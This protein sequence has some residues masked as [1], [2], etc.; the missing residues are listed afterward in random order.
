MIKFSQRMGITPAVKEIQ[1]N[2]ID[3]EL[4]NGL[5][6]IYNE[7]LLKS[8]DNSAYERHFNDH[9]KKFTYTLWH[10]FFKWILETAPSSRSSLKLIIKDW[11]F[12]A[13]WY[14]IYDLIQF[15]CDCLRDGGYGIYVLEIEN[16]FNVVLER[17]FAGYRFIEGHLAPIT[18]ESEIKDLK[19]AFSNT[20]RF[21]SLKGCNIHLE[22]SL[23]KLSDRISPDYRNSIKES[24]SA[25]ESL[26][27]VIS[28]KTS[29][30]LNSAI[31]RIK[32]KIKIHRNLEQGIKNLYNYT[33]DGD[34]IRHGMMDEST[35][36]F[37]DA[38]FMLIS[39]S[40]FINYLIVKANKAG[41]E[42][43]NL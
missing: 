5:W 23:H 19:E 1:L 33:S 14:E 30:T 26:A 11:F 27:K 15:S 25:V 21:S 28:G 12:N 4:K 38:K 32:G 36:D 31:D 42:F 20:E 37:E 34:G 43:Q 8:L 24:I 16:H 9:E 17:E 41:I 6:N 7:I 18:N 2:E 35:C 40:A 13:N 3:A 22:A 10:N 39:C 29:D